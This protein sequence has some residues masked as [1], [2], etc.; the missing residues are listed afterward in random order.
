MVG[1]EVGWDGNTLLEP[2]TVGIWLL[3]AVDTGGLVG[4]GG[5][6]EGWSKVVASN[7]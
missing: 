4:S 3:E 6:E 7:I 5:R 2:L 1:A